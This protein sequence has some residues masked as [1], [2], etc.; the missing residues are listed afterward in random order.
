[1][2]LRASGASLADAVAVGD[3][4]QTDIAAAAAMGLPSVLV[5]TGISRREDIATSQAKPDLV[6]ERL[7]DLLTYDLEAVARR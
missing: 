7:P 5:L 3:N 1:M 4:L 2:L 6:V